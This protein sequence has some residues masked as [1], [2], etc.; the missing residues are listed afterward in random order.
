MI[1]IYWKIKTPKF[2]I[3]NNP[4]LTFFFDGRKRRKAIKFDRETLASRRHNLAYFLRTTKP[5]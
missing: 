3:L 4:H 2:I 5:R 1:S